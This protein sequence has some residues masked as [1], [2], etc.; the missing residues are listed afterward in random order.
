LASCAASRLVARR[1]DRAV[2]ERERVVPPLGD[3]EDHREPLERGVR[4]GR[5]LDDAHEDL[6]EDLRVI[7]E[8]LVAEAPRALADHL[9]DLGPDVTLERLLVERDDVV[10]SIEVRRQGLDLFPGAHRVRRVF[11]GGGCFLEL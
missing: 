2:V 1:A 10:R 7:A 11:D 3:G 9:G 5:E 8:P 4:R 6:L